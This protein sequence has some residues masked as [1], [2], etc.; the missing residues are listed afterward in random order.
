MVNLVLIEQ[1]DKVLIEG[2]NFFSNYTLITKTLSAELI[3]S[4]GVKLRISMKKTFSVISKKVRNYSKC[5]NKENVKLKLFGEFGISCTNKD[6]QLANS[7]F[8]YLEK[9]R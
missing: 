3:G 8:S 7:L 1:I 5:W 9:S 6:W 4:I 2:Q